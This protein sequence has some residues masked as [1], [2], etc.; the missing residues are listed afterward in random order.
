MGRLEAVYAGSSPL[1]HQMY[2]YGSGL[3][4]Y[5]LA[6]VIPSPG[7]A[8]SALTLYIHPST[9][10]PV[11]CCACTLGTRTSRRAALLA[12]RLHHH[13][14]CNK[15]GRNLSLYGYAGGAEAQA[16][17]SGDA[18]KK[19]LRREIDDLARR[20]ALQVRSCDIFSPHDLGFWRAP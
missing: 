1:I 20:K 2:I 11:S 10:S 4:S 5:L 9:L 14:K 7:A 13:M 15:G 6:V 16:K 19:L 18:L 17:S 3:R 8:P 12:W